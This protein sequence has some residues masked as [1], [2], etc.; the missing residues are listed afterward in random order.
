LVQRLENARLTAHRLIGPSTVRVNRLL[1]RGVYRRGYFEL[2]YR[3]RDPWKYL[4]SDY[5]RERHQRMLAWCCALEPRRILELGCSEGVFTAALAAFNAEV[6]ALDISAR[7]VARARARCA[8]F[9]RAQIVQADVRRE[10]PAG[11]FDL[12]VCTE[13]LYYLEL[14]ALAGMRDRLVEHLAPGGSLL[15][16]H[17][18]PQAEL[19]HQQVF[20]RSPAL[21]SIQ[22]ELV[23]ENPRPYAIALFQRQS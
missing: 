3:R 6:V 22:T 18:W 12:I 11:R 15:L 19:F 4:T 1:G 9:P 20:A 14:R 21:T 7:A 13:L 5:E 17:G 16:V 8:D 23:S 10:I 2:R